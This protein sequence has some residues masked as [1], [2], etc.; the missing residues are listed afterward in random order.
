MINIVGRGSNQHQKLIEETVI[1][2]EDLGYN[3]VNMNGI[4]PDAVATRDGK[5]YAIEVLVI[6][7]IPKKGWEHLKQ[8]RDKKESYSMFDDIIFKVSNRDVK[9][10]TGQD[11]IKKELEEK[12]KNIVNDF[13][14]DLYNHSEKI[15]R[16][17]D[18]L[19][20]E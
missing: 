8:I 17:E 2:L 7:K 6:N 14:I 5:I 18:E 15:E 1:E 12:A 10:L 11:K 16:I 4:A 19:K 20:S 13:L 3:V 9:I